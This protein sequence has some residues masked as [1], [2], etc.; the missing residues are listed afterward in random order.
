MD[1]TKPFQRA[2]LPYL[3]L[4]SLGST[5]P[6]CYKA[7]FHGSICCH[8]WKLTWK[9]WA[10]W[11]VKIF[12]WLAGMNCCWTVQHLA[13]KDLRHKPACLFR[14]Q[15]LETMQYLLANCLFSRVIWHEVLSSICSTFGGLVPG[16][17]LVDQ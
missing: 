14:G 2:R 15:T 4:D 6:D 1:A 3:A 13:L 11:K 12:F 7:T 17:T 10:P 16:E 9:S 5:P 8:A